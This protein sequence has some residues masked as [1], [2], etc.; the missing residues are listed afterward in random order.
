MTVSVTCG[1]VISFKYLFVLE[2]V[3]HTAL[4]GTSQI[5]KCVPSPTTTPSPH[6]HTPFRSQ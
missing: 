1:E 3:V 4:H 2:S 5:G 6:I